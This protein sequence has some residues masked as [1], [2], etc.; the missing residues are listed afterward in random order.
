MI[1]KADDRRPGL[2]HV[3]VKRVDLGI[4]MQEGLY[5]CLEANLVDTAERNI[6]YDDKA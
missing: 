5:N 6:R 4:R 1:D 2:A 3:E